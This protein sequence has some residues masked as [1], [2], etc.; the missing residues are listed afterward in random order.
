MIEGLMQQIQ[1]A[2]DPAQRR[3]LLSLHLQALREE[4]R[5]IRASRA[6]MKMSMQEDGKKDAGSM[7]KEGGMM[8]G[9][10]MMHKEV[11]QR[12]DMLERL[13]QQ[14]IEREAAEQR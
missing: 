11:E 13:M 14:M 7:M 2:D 8:G 1:Q 12:L 5:L 6:G 9:G 3:E 10:M 4:M